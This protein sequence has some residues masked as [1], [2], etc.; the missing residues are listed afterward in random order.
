MCTP[1]YPTRTMVIA[2]AMAFDV[3]SG[4]THSTAYMVTPATTI[5]TTSLTLTMSSR[6]SLVASRVPAMAMPIATVYRP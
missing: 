2:A 1:T 5:P 3:G 6:L 4:I